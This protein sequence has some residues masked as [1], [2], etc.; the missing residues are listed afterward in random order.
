MSNMKGFNIECFDNIFHNISYLGVLSF[1][2]LLSNSSKP[3]FIKSK[4]LKF[5]AYLQI[6]MLCELKKVKLKF[7]I[8]KK[9]AQ[10][11]CYVACK[12]KK[13]FSFHLFSAVKAIS[14]SL[15]R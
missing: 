15:N 8:K 2:F 5:G 4:S 13:I 10:Q 14:Y 6:A 12:P 9:K 11:I 1:Y 3:F 7:P